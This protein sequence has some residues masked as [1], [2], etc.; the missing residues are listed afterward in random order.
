VSRERLDDHRRLW[1]AKPVLAAVYRPWFD[2]LL[3]EAPLRGRALEIGAGPGFLRDHARARRPDLR[4]IATDIVGTPWNDVA[5]DGGR[6]P[7]TAA[8]F[9]AVL[10]LDL[11]HHLARPRDF[12]VEVARVLGPGGRLAAVEPWVTP[13]S[14]PIYRWAHEEGCNLSIDPW[15]PFGAGPKEAFEGDGA[16]AWRVVRGASEAEWA[17]MGFAPPRV[18]LLNA[19]AYLLSLGFR[20]G[21]LLPRALAPLA[22]RV[23]HATR[24]LAPLTAMRALV[25]W[26]KATAGRIPPA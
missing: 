12:F 17:A 16:L 3:A 6:L 14:Y 15:A 25:V 4:W 24:A 7:F 22:A 9:D 5:A 11:V 8:A 21:S 1:S 2:A 18:R 26:E 13:F 10:C 20:E 23:D 19:F